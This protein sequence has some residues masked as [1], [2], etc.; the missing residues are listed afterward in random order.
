[1]TEFRIWEVQPV[2]EKDRDVKGRIGVE[3]QV[4][5]EMEETRELSGRL[6]RELLEP[7]PSQSQA[8]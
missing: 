3:K 7:W 4:Q 8:S 2:I 5:E 1:M 6:L